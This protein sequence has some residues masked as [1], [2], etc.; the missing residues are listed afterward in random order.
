VEATIGSNKVKQALELSCP[1]FHD[2]EAQLEYKSTLSFIRAG[3]HRFEE[4]FCRNA[5]STVPPN[6]TIGY[7]SVFQLMRH[8]VRIF[9][10]PDFRPGDTQTLFAIACR[11]E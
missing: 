9:Q 4:L 6:Y 2:P 8:G 1:P 11:V 5:I 7:R 10:A 3:L